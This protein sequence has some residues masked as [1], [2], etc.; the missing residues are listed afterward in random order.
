MRS[1][2]S[3]AGRFESQYPSGAESHR[4]ASCP[5]GVSCAARPEARRKPCRQISDLQGNGAS[6][7]TTAETHCASIARCNCDFIVKRIGDTLAPVHGAFVHAAV[8][9]SFTVGA[10]RAALRPL[11]LSRREHDRLDNLDDR[12]LDS[13]SGHVPRD[14]RPLPGGSDRGCAPL[15]RFA[16]ASPVRRIRPSSNAGRARRRISLVAITW[17]AAPAPAC[18][19]EHRLAQC[20]V[21]RLCRLHRDNGV[22][23]RPG[24]AARPLQ[25]AAHRGDVRRSG[26]VA[27]SSGVDRRCAARSRYR[28]GPH[29]RHGTHGSPSVH[30]ARANRRRAT[31]VC[32][33]RVGQGRRLASARF[34][35][36]M[37]VPA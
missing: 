36:E 30:V 33:R 11:L 21:P 4:H 1:H 35:S 14:A 8:P 7:A 5:V 31:H 20:L 37:L 27:L 34:H 24:R 13:S 10:T 15:S 18:F 29:T 19:T 9:F 12:P 22:L 17:R 23:R 6:G 2:D 26:V 32:P 25:A 28:C 3:T 16:A